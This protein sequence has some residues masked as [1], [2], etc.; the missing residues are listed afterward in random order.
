MK[1]HGNVTYF[2]GLEFHYNSLGVFLN[3]HK[4]T[5]DLITLAGLQ[6][7]S[8]INTPFKLNVKCCHGEGDILPDTTMYRQLVESLNYLTITWLDISFAVQQVSQFM[9]APRNLYFVV[10]HHII[11]CLL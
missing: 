4:Y 1:D 6:E 7:S 11:R 8:S 3:Q 2:L 10:V 9:Q 5:Q